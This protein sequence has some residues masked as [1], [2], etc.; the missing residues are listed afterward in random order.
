MNR[1]RKRRELREDREARSIQRG[2]SE[3]SVLM[4]M[5]APGATAEQYER[6][7][8]IMGIR[9]DADA[10]EGLIQHGA[11][12]DDSGLVV[13]YVWE[14]EDA[15]SGFVD[16]RL[17]AALEQA[18]LA[19]AAGQAPVMHVHKELEGAPDDAGIAVL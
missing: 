6:T 7:N 16:G 8:E 5:E 1:L 18:G 15:R 14:S 12:I 9:G 11:A 10:P 4:V 3:M 19:S 17:G 13:A 2:R